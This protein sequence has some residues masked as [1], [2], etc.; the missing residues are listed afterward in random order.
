VQGLDISL[1]WYKY[2]ISDMIIADSVD[3]ILRE[4]YVAGDASRC[5]SHTRAADGH[6]N[7]M[8]YGL[9]NLGRMET[10]GYDLGI[11]YRL[12]EL[13]IGQFAIDWQTSYLSKYDEETQNGE[14]NTVM[15]GKVG[16]AGLFRVRS[17]VGITWS[18]GD[19]GVSYMARYYSGMKEDCVAAR[20]CT[21]PDRYVNGDAMPVRKTGSNTFHDLQVSYNAP[22]D[23]TIA[24]GANNLFD[25]QGPIM[26]T[27][28]NSSFAYYGG[29]DIGRF[30]Y[31][32]YTQRF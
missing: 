5:A 16:D 32:K 18:R 8:N 1:D 4:C 2:E 10:E 31:M 26:F 22:W 27:Q 28:P 24:L 12:P 13:S 25:K 17:N 15:E 6:I 23:A 21:L 11:K 3:R 7:S 29:F 20:P 9:A 19:F 30:L 14:G